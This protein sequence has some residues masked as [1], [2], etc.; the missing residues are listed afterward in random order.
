MGNSMVQSLKTLA[1]GIGGGLIMLAMLA[2]SVGGL[3][4][5]W[6]A[7]QIGSFLMF[8]VG[9][10]PLFFIVTGPVGAWGL[11]FGMPNWVFNI[12]G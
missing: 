6:V 9:V 4:W 12:F 1:S 8:L 2:I 10:F 3:Y 11:L 5:L 7:I